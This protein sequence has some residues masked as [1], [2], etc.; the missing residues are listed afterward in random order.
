MCPRPHCATKIE[1]LWART[2]NPVNP[3]KCGTWLRWMSDSASFCAPFTPFKMP[4][5]VARACPSGIDR[6]RNLFEDSSLQP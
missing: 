2:P 6:L 1:R 4:T 5:M 3:S